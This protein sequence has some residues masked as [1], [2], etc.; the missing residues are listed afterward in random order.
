MAVSRY[1]DSH[2]PAVST[3]VELA[4]KK[5]IFSSLKKPKTSKAQFRFLGF[6]FLWCNLINKPYIQIFIV[7]C[8]IHQFHRL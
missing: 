2:L 6:L 8:E 3:V 1:W 5:S 7:I 4:F